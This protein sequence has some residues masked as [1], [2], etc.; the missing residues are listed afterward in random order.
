NGVLLRVTID[1]AYTEYAQGDCGW[2]YSTGWGGKVTADAC[3]KPAWL[4]PDSLGCDTV[5]TSQ[6]LAGKWGLVRRGGCNFTIKAYDA[7]KAGAEAVIVLNDYTTD[8]A[9]TGCT[10]IY[11]S[12]A[13]NTHAED[14]TVPVISVGRD[15]AQKITDALNANQNIELCFVFPRMYNP[16]AAYHYAT[17]VSQVDTLS[18]IGVRFVNR[19]TEM[20]HDVTIKADVRAP[21]GNVTTL[22]TLLASVP[23]GVDSFVY[24]PAY[25]PP[26]VL[27]RFNV[28]YS[29]SYYTEQRDSL[30]RSFQH[31]PYTFATDNLTID[32]LGVATS[33]ENFALANFQQQSGGLCLT[34][35]NGGVGAYATFGIANAAALAGTGADEVI[36]ILYD[37]DPDDD[38]V[39]DFSGGFTDLDNLNGGPVGFG[40]YT[41]T[42]A[43]P[44]DS[45][46]TVA[47]SDFSSGGDKVT[48]KPRHPYYISLLYNG[49]NGTTG[50]DIAFSNS[51]SELYLNYPTTPL[52]LDVLYS[53]FSG[54]TI[55]QRLQ[56][57][58]YPANL[59][60]TKPNLLN[61]TKVAITPNPANDQIRLDLQLSKVNEAVTV[62]LIDWT[63][64]FVST[65]L[66]KNFQSGQTTFEVST[67]PSG[68][69]LVQV[70]ASEGMTMRKVTVCH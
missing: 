32:P 11:M 17:P 4:R 12:A 53:G 41:M 55:I 68:T 5:V 61:E 40:S 51:T 28:T 6:S 44:V 7:Q 21:N 67:L 24:L 18:N 49:S 15:I 3:G 1:G 63:G 10:P 48:L 20:L 57:E 13:V 39:I 66:L 64:R 23:A 30:R 38:G 31:T 45:L 62:S 46:L 65:Q 54:A 69:Y 29:N 25:G 9:N 56:M 58:G 47:L 34:G 26:A 35:P 60:S 70:S 16:V 59:V 19:G 2:G 37:G 27:G 36:V 22:T 8:P 14:V 42:G 33:D 43:E 52:F 50:K